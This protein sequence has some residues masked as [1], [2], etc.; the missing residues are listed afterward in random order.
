MRFRRGTRNGSPPAPSSPTDERSGSADVTSAPEAEPGAIAPQVP[1]E[2]VGETAS[3]LPFAAGAEPPSAAGGSALAETPVAESGIPAPT[4]PH[5]GR[6]SRWFR[7]G[8]AARHRHHRPRRRLVVAVTVVAVV[9]VAASGSVVGVRLSQRYPLATVRPKIP[10]AAVIPG[11]VP[12]ITWPAEV[13]AAYAIPELGVSG[14]SGREVPVPIASVTKL[15]T[16]HVILTDHPLAPGQPGPSIT[17]TPADVATY[18]E[19]VATGQTNI[20]VQAGEVLDEYQL[21]EGMLVHSANNFADLLAELDA[22]TL[23]AFVAKMNAAAASL[24]MTDT[25]YAD[26]SGYDTSTVSTPVDQLTV[27]TLDISSPLFDQIVDMS[28]VTLPVVGTVPSYTPF[29]G[30]NGVVGLKSGFT[31]AAGGCDVLGLL[32]GFDGLPVEVL[33][34]VLGYQAGTDLVDGAG[35]DALSVAR[36]AMAGVQVLTAFRRGE[37][38]GT[39]TTGSG[40]VSI[41][42]R[43]RAAVVGWPGQRVSES[44]HLARRPRPGAH[45]GFLVGR[46][47]VTLGFQRSEVKVGTGRRFPTPTFWQRVF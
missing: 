1:A 8:D 4:S 28:S 47:T 21:L 36:E 27:A 43:G 40:S 20:E 35:V 5:P 29:V 15:M 6:V 3:A 41:V 45:R 39:A 23:P 12:T 31:S 25:H 37:R 13:Q 18:N 9:L 22:G 38:V 30:T 2:P 16:A 24:G 11:T 14:E 42:S 26:A 19:D 44:F 10:V 46:V 34:V 32:H 7:R 33:V 17:V